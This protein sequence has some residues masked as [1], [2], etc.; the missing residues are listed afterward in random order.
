MSTVR[1]VFAL[2]ICAYS[3]PGMDEDEYHEYMS[4]VHAASVRDLMVKNKIVGYSMVRERKRQ[5][6]CGPK[7]TY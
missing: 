7:N 5:P 1:R 3:K 4:K 6:Q 2:T